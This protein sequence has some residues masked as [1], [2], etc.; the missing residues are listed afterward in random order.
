MFELSGRHLRAVEPGDLAAAIAELDRRDGV[1][2]RHGGAVDRL[3]LGRAPE[4]V[5]E[6]G[7][8]AALVLLVEIYQAEK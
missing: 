3:A 6:I 8:K 2:S 1:R 4:V 5:D 7:Q